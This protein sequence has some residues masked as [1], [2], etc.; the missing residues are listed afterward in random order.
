[1]EETGEETS[2]LMLP[3][4]GRARKWEDPYYLGSDSPLLLI[5]RSTH[6]ASLFNY[7]SVVYLF[8]LN[9]WL[10]ERNNSFV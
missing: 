4:W 6:L 9:S 8:V 10:I 2:N 7:V 3:V 1:M 5:N